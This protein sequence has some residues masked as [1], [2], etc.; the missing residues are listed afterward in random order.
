MSLFRKNPG[1]DTGAKRR[2]PRKYQT[3]RYESGVLRWTDGGGH[4]IQVPGMTQAYLETRVSEMTLSSEP[5][6]EQRAEEL[7]ESW[8]GSPVHALED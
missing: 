7:I 8:G 4:V 2:M 6:T 1:P 3:V 5:I